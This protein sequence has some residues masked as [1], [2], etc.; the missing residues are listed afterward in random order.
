MKTFVRQCLV[1]PFALL[2]ACYASILSVELLA[3]V[4]TPIDD[5][6]HAADDRMHRE[7]ILTRTVRCFKGC[8]ASEPWGVFAR[9]SGSR[10][11]LDPEPDSGDA[12]HKSEQNTLTAGLDRLFGQHLLG[13]ALGASN[14]EARVFRADESRSD[15]DRDKQSIG[16]YY[17]L[18]LPHHFNI[19]AQLLFSDYDYHS[20]LTGPDMMPD[21]AN[22]DA[23]GYSSGF[24]VST[25]IPLI[26]NDFEFTA[27]PSISYLYVRTETDPYTSESGDVYV[28]STSISGEWKFALKWRTVIDVGN[29]YLFP[30]AGFS[31]NRLER[32]F[33]RANESENRDQT[34][35]EGIL[36]LTVQREN[37]N[38]SAAYQQTIAEDLYERKQ[39]QLTFR[40][41]F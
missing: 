20:E 29:A 31:Y 18:Q 3:D 17:G 8:E 11:R 41:V 2:V 10:Q 27:Q 30:V 12:R 38:L 9:L 32:T 15:I 28:K 1:I 36:G 23:H 13:I 4:Y 40:V 14:G 25:F 26:T 35:F 7:K 24:S 34:F 16:M 37:F 6:D 19:T 22:Y 33:R 39:Y 21:F 5:P